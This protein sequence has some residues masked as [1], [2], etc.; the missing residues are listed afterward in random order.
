MEMS[1][2]YYKSHWIDIEPDRHAVYDDLLKFHPAMDRLL[3][4]L[5]LQPGLKVLDVGSGP[6]HTTMAIAQRVL[7]GGHATGAD[8]NAEFVER[9][10]KRA[11]AAGLASAI[12]YRHCE[13]PPLPFADG[14]FD[15]VWC[16][17]VLEYVDDAAATVAEMARVTAPGGIVV[18]VD[19]DWEMM[20]VEL[21]EETRERTESIL[22]AAKAI[23][24]NER[25]IGRRLFHLFLAA[26]L[27]G[28]EIRVFAN[29]DR[30][31]LMA[32]MLRNSIA[33]YARDSGKVSAAAVAQWLADLERALQSGRYLFLLPQFLVSGRKSAAHG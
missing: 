16:K 22:N 5:Q 23:A 19:S 18:A 32:G 20:A 8:I 10:G 24:I 2:P 13:F 29:P 7:P 33:R 1:D 25:R 9:A 11:A 27:D 12:D 17:N 14:S 3:E 6:G 28:V 15:R 31:G 30:K 26:G 21:G 4:P